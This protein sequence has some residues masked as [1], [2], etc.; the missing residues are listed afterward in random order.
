M[1][2]R[3]HQAHH[4]TNHL[5]SEVAAPAPELL[6][7]VAGKSDAASEQLQQQA[8][9]LAEHLQSR[10]RHLVR[11][12]ASLNARSAE[13]DDQQRSARLWL[14]ERQGELDQREHELQRQFQTL[15][16]QADDVQ[17]ADQAAKSLA[18]KQEQVRQAEQALQEQRQQLDDDAGQCATPSC[19][20]RGR[21]Q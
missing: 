18:Q 16:E 12:E 21:P 4:S 20:A 19:L 8:A 6:L 10:Q 15:E 5:P 2:P 14:R 3:F 17:Q 7:A 1:E 9:E 13:Y 11:H